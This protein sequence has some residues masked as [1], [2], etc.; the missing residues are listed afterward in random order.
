M[1]DDDFNIIIARAAFDH[2][3]G[4]TFRDGVY[5]VPCTG[6][7]T[8]GE[9]TAIDDD[10]AQLTVAPRHPDSCPLIQ[11][12]RRLRTTAADLIARHRAHAL[13]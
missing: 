9:F 2:M 7:G 8:V 10:F 4:V 12:V 11:R 13:N 6:C 1:S 3:R 5:S